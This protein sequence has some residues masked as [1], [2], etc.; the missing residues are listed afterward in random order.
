MSKL[1]IEKPNIFLIGSNKTKD[2]KQDRQNQV[3][4]PVP[5]GRQP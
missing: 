4:L 2:P 3:S 5:E 1:K